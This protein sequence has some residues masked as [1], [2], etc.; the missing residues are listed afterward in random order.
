M[1]DDNSTPRARTPISASGGGATRPVDEFA[2]TTVVV[3]D[4][5]V[6]SEQRS[7]HRSKRPPP[8][9]NRKAHKIKRIKNQR[10][11]PWAALEPE[12][13]REIASDPR[14]SF[15]S[16]AELE[17]SAEARAVGA[18]TL[19]RHDSQLIDEERERE[20]ERRKVEPDTSA[21]GKTTAAQAFTAAQASSEPGTDRRWLLLLRV[22]RD[23]LARIWD[24]RLESC[25][26]S[27]WRPATKTWA[28]LFE[29]PQIATL[30]TA[31][32][33]QR[34]AKARAS[35]PASPAPRRRQAS[36][37]SHA[38]AGRRS[39]APPGAPQTQ[40]VAGQLR[41]ALASL[42]ETQASHH[43][44]GHASHQL[45]QPSRNETLRPS[46]MAELGGESHP[47]APA[48]R[49]ALRSPYIPPP[50]RVPSLTAT[51]AL[52]VHPA[53]ADE[54]SSGPLPSYAAA[55]LY[56]QSAPD[57]QLSAYGAEAPHPYAQSLPTSAA[58]A[59]AAAQ[60][61]G[62]AQAFEAA[63]PS[64]SDARVIPL[65][66]R[67]ERDEG[68]STS[69]EAF[70]HF[71]PSESSFTPAPD[72]MR[73]PPPADSYVPHAH[74][75]APLQSPRSPGMGER[76]G[77]LFAGVAAAL[78]LTTFTGLGSSMRASLAGWFDP[79]PT[80]VSQGELATSEDGSES[81]PTLPTSSGAA[82]HA[83][84]AEKDAPNMVSVE[85]L[86][87]LTKSGAVVPARDRED[88]RESEPRRHE[89]ETERDRTDEPESHTASR[90]AAKAFV[91][92]AVHATPPPPKPAAPQPV[93]FDAAAARR[94]LASA[95]GR[96]QFCAGER[97]NG[98]IVVTFAPAGSVASVSLA[99]IS[100]S[101]VRKGCVLNAFRGARITPF[102]GDPVTVQKSFQLR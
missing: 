9:P 22:G 54:S 76:A 96:A 88:D 1:R 57:G 90:S 3:D 7:A 97:A 59:F 32:V 84:E 71:P 99:N 102:Q 43:H 12:R 15:L 37:V 33:K 19:V 39:S 61:F 36:G 91:A 81:E 86:P 41:A 89:R 24:G 67:T 77:W 87:V 94:A 85:E 44:P 35:V 5:I 80:L 20:A 10:S 55:E 64:Y 70:Q 50:P 38:G 31:T 13:L 66:R 47:L 79:K 11:T 93:R 8:L 78:V 49:L 68:F 28:P 73:A 101:D 62:A 14:A 82:S 26:P 27:V 18:T 21:P 34:Q 69:H 16:E 56:R 40:P 51:A 30:V 45:A 92:P 95:V 75:I 53:F 2:E 74:T 83:D 46:S 63:Q 72:S 52:R 25:E 4:S 100:G 60:A 6:R 29:V 23:E 58:E 42:P 65:T 48:A 98:T 17:E